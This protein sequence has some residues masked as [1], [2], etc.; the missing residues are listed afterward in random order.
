LIALSRDGKDADH[1][2]GGPRSLIEALMAAELG[3]LDHSNMII[4]LD[5]LAKVEA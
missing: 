1:K 4:I 2:T 5:D 3:D